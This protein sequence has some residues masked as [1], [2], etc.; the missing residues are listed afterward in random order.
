MG[1]AALHLIAQRLLLLA[2]KHIPLREPIAGLRP[3]ASPACQSL[4]LVLVAQDIIIP[5]GLLTTPAAVVGALVI[6]TIIL[7]RRAVLIPWWLAKVAAMATVEIAILRPPALLKAAAVKELFLGVRD[8]GPE[9]LTQA[10]AA[11]TAA[12]AV[13][14][15]MRHAV[16]TGAA[17]VAALAGMQATVALVGTETQAATRGLLAQAAAVLVVQVAAD[18]LLAAVA[19]LAFLAKARLAQ[20]AICPD[21]ATPDREVQALSMVAA[22]PA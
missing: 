6:K 17:A 12:Q 18:G 8:A 14:L 3:L 9:A 16:F 20:K 22:V 13:A 5:A 7:S 1:R 11:V 2:S 21:R 15:P 19:A 10:M 4:L